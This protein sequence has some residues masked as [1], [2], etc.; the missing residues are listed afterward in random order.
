MTD[1]YGQLTNKELSVSYWWVTHRL[2]LRMLF[3]VLVCLALLAVY[4]NAGWQLYRYISST[5]QHRLM[6]FEL[7]TN[8]I[9]YERIRNDTAPLPLTIG[10]TLASGDLSGY[11]LSTLVENPNSRW[12]LK[13][14]EYYYILG[15]ETTEPRV[16]SVLPGDKKYLIHFQLSENTQVASARLFIKRQLWQRVRETSQLDK[17]N[18]WL[19]PNVIAENI[20]YDS[21][22]PAAK[23]TRFSFEL[24]N[25]SPHN[26]WAVECQLLVWQGS[27]LVGIY[28]L[29]VNDLRSN[30]KRLVEISWPQSFI[31]GLRTEVLVFPDSLSE[32]N[33]RLVPA[34]PN[35]I[36]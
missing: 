6:L 1:E 26:F 3:F 34:G 27:R 19:R 23:Q 18:R 2:Q 20:K 14:I 5:P 15:T 13:E 30:E 10:Q 24:N 16:T 29:M 11:D 32:N 9:D 7:T 4:I 17:N 36:R 21:T 31:T 35:I 12:W 28:S 22:N 33:I 25:V 8:N